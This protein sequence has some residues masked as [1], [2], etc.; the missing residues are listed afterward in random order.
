MVMAEIP[1]QGHSAEVGAIVIG[2]LVMFGVACGVTGMGT[3]AV[4]LSE[5]VPPVLALGLAS[6]AIVWGF[7]R[8]A[9]RK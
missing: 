1:R 4:Q 6:V 3:E 2:L 9:F 8:L 5:A 7:S